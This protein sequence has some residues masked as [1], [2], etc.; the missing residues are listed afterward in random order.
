MSDCR[1]DCLCDGSSFCNCPFLLLFI[2]NVAVDFD[3]DVDFLDIEE[4]PLL[5]GTDV[6][7]VTSLIP[8]NPLRFSDGASTFLVPSGGV[9]PGTCR[10]CGGCNGGDALSP[11]GDCTGSTNVTGDY[12]SATRSIAIVD[13]DIGG[14]P[15]GDSDTGG[16]WG[17]RRRRRRRRRWWGRSAAGRFRL[18][19]D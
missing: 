3:D 2:A 1:S 4:V 7:Y 5:I 8:I 16:C 14:I 17:R 9:A 13:G 19:L 6:F 18:W 15:L 11:C 10:P 12:S